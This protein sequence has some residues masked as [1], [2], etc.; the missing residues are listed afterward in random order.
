MITKAFCL[1]RSV[2]K[3]QD[4]R[5][6]NLRNNNDYR[7]KTF[8]YNQCDLLCSVVSVSQCSQPWNKTV[9]LVSFEFLFFHLNYC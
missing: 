3:L 4:L 6:D 2:F 9:H 1:K 8:C 5:T 7:Y